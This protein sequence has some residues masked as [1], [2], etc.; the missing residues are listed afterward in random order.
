[1]QCSPRA[2]A[3]QKAPLSHAVGVAMASR[4]TATR[5][6]CS[7]RAAMHYQATGWQHILS[8]AFL[9]S[10]LSQI[11]FSLCV[12][13][14]RASPILLWHRR[15]H[16]LSETLSTSHLMIYAS[17]VME[18]I[19]PACITVAKLCGHVTLRIMTALLSDQNSRLRN[20][21]V[22]IFSSLFFFSALFSF[23]FFLLVCISFF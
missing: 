1:M 16:S 22:F 2:I 21:C 19:M 20:T 4:C 13:P 6:S 18:T 5:A 23:S 10:S 3:Y 17:G 15:S 12:G 8:L 11:L 7:P 14:L 9:S